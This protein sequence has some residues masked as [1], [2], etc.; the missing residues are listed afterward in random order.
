MITF[1]CC[2]T[3]TCLAPLRIHERESSAQTSNGQ[4]KHEPS[5]PLAINC[6]ADHLISV[7]TIIWRFYDINTECLQLLLEACLYLIKQCPISI[8]PKQF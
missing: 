3:Y 7:M 5:E 1:N 4:G 6:H 8:S 2:K